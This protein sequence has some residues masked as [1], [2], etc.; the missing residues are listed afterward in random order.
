MSGTQDRDAGPRLTFDTAG[1]RCECGGL[2]AVTD[3]ARVGDGWY[4]V[5]WLTAHRRGCG[6]LAAPERAFLVNGAAFGAGDYALP[7]LPGDR[8]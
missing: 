4:L 3:A 8:P 6:G 2:G 1:M 7:G 5:S